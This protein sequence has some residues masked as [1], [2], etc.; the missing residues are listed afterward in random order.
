[1]QTYSP[2]FQTLYD[3]NSP[4]GSLGRGTHYS[5][6][7]AIVFHDHIGKPLPET[8]YKGLQARY[9]DFAII[10]DEDHDTRVIEAIQK[11]Y[12]EGLLPFFSF[13]GERKAMLTALAEADSD[14][15]RTYA[16]LR[17]EEI[18]SDIHNDCWTSDIGIFRKPSGIISANPD[19][20]MLY[21][22][23]IHMLWRLG[24]KPIAYYRPPQDLI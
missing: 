6:L 2:F 19:D 12:T 20:E 18:C 24:S 22:A 4:V 9:H 10:W 3:E 15:L 13:F 1:M 14:T 5:V 7:R 17:I 16:K 8:H 11:I 21:L 23:N